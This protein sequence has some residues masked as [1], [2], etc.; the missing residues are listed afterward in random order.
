MQVKPLPPV[1]FGN[2][3]TRIEDANRVAS[4]PMPI[5][6]F[7]VNHWVR[8]RDRLAAW[9]AR[10][11]LPPSSRQLSPP[12]EFEAGIQPSRNRVRMT[13]VDGRCAPSPS[14]E[15]FVAGR[16]ATPEEVIDLDWHH[17]SASALHSMWS[18][19]GSG[20]TWNAGGPQR[21]P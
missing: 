21:S 20:E 11:V 19:Q 4:C 6:A 8:S 3:C 18:A 5:F 10:N 17:A 15:S 12:S 2:R 13:A 14:S 1:Y 7:A 9:Q 16:N